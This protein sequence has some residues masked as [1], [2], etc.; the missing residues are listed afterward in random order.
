[1]MKSKTKTAYF[2]GTINGNN[3][4]EIKVI[5][6][7]KGLYAVPIGKIGQR[8]TDPKIALPSCLTDKF[9]RY[10]VPSV[11]VLVVAILLF[12]FLGHR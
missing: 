12:A 4:L 9:E 5:K 1:M 10:F 2:A 6:E 7:A 11:L 8:G 3:T